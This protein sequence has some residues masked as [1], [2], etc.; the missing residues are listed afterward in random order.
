MDHSNADE[1][2]VRALSLG[3]TRAWNMRDGR[4]FGELFTE[5]G[6]IIGFD[7]SLVE[8]S[9]A[10]GQEMSAIFAHHQTPAYVVKM[11]TVRF[12]AD[13]VA[14]L[15]CSAGMPSPLDGRINPTLNSMQSLVAVKRDGVW[16]VALFQNTPAQFHG[17]PDLVQKM[18]AELQEQL[19][20]Y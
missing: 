12:I 20:R 18:S 6:A 3:L 4:A 2:A 5:D 17:R 13:D 19:I 10:I 16:R 7:G 11:H 1:A 14:V 8:G 15:R 9:E